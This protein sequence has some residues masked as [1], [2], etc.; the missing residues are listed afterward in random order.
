MLR[1][2]K[3]DEESV[4]HVGT[5]LRKQDWDEVIGLTGKDPVQVLVWGR[6]EFRGQQSW[7]TMDGGHTEA[8]RE[9]P[10]VYA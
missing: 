9:C 1:V 4:Y 8:D 7:R 10:G 2:V 3:A 5:N 6:P